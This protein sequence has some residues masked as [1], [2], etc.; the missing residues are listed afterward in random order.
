MERFGFRPP[1]PP[2]SRSSTSIAPE[3]RQ[4][5]DSTAGVQLWGSAM[6]SNSHARTQIREQ[7]STLENSMIDPRLL[8]MNVPHPDL[9]K[10]SDESDSSSDG[11]SG[12]SDGDDDDAGGEPRSTLIHGISRILMTLHGRP[13]RMGAVS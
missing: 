7:T 13:P 9:D 4:Q 3:L 12:G 11:E 2:P 6:L 1:T 8:N 5:F 10:D